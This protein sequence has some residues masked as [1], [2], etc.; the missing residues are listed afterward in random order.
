[1][2]YT[3]KHARI[4]ALWQM[5]QQQGC[6]PWSY[7]AFREWSEPRWADNAILAKIF[8]DLPWGPDNAEWVGGHDPD[9]WTHQWGNAYRKASMPEA[10]PCG[11][12]RLAKRCTKWCPS[13]AKWWDKKMEEVRRLVV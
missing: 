6:E 9:A 7:E 11:G 12:C 1:M 3:K 10:N 8:P 13:R 5:M 2:A 4:S